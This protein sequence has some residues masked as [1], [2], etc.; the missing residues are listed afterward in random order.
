MRMDGGKRVWTTLKGDLD[1]SKWINGEAQKLENGCNGTLEGEGQGESPLNIAKDKVTDAKL[2]H[3]MRATASALL[4]DESI[5]LYKKANFEHKLA[6]LE[7]KICNSLLPSWFLEAHTTCELQNYLL[8]LYKNHLVIFTPQVEWFEDDSCHELSVPI[9]SVTAGILLCDDA[10][11]FYVLTR[12]KGRIENKTLWSL[13]K[14]PMLGEVPKLFEGT[15]L[16]TEFKKQLTYDKNWYLFLKHFL[17]I[18]LKP[19]TM[20]RVGRHLIVFG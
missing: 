10:Y 12:M 3:L 9:I 18:T 8:N 13:T 16:N 14:L 20:F 15:V 1:L 17:E 2:D 19:A 7:A 6:K 5:D 11:K 4:G